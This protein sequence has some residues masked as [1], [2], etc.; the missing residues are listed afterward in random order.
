MKSQLLV[1]VKFDTSKVDKKIEEIQ[2]TLPEGVFEFFRDVISG[3]LGEVILSDISSAGGALSVSEV[4]CTLDFDPGAY[5]KI[6]STARAF[7][8]HLTHQKQSPI[9][10]KSP[11]EILEHFN[12][13][14]FVDDHG[15]RLEF[16]Q[17][18]IDLVMQATK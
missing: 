5:D 1:S 11:E 9:N 12:K 3:L 17:D 14:N 15:H 7:K 16:C 8:A 4:V 2:S 13:Y 10:G 6:L 18:F